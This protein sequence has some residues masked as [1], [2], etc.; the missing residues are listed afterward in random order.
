MHISVCFNPLCSPL[1][2]SLRAFLLNSAQLYSESHLQPSSDSL[3][4]QVFSL[5]SITVPNIANIYSLSVPLSFPP[6][7]KAFFYAVARGDDLS[8][9]L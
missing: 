7:K 2:S 8:I 3:P 4:G 6:N 5:V 1:S 9:E